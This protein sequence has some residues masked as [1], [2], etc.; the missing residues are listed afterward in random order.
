MTLKLEPG[1]DFTLYSSMFGK[2]AK[3]V[4]IH[5]QENWNLEYEADYITEAYIFSD[6]TIDIAE[7]FIRSQDRDFTTNTIHVIKLGPCV[8]EQLLE[9]S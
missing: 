1:H 6:E 9:N 3:A 4:K 7:E 8:N 2:F 5:G